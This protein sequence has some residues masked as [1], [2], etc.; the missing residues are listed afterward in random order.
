M[1]CNWNIK[2]ILSYLLFLWKRDSIFGKCEISERSEYMQGKAYTDFLLEISKLT[3]KLDTLSENSCSALQEWKRVKK[4][5]LSLEEYQSVAGHFLDHCSVLE[6]TY[7]KLMSE[8]IRKFRQ[9]EE[10]LDDEEL[11]SLRKS[12]GN[13]LWRVFLFWERYQSHKDES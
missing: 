6:E 4:R 3:S 2:G 11:D 9:A 7:D 8:L 10:F 12:V 1:L 13:D 5:E